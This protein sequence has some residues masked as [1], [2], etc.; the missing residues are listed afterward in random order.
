MGAQK[1]L[2]AGSVT[3][4]QLKDLFRQFEDK[5][6][7]GDHLQALLEHRNPF[8]GEEP[9]EE[10]NYPQTGI[11]WLRIYRKLGME[12]EFRTALPNLNQV[13]ANDNLWWVPVI[14]GLTSNKIVACLR[15]LG[16][17]VD[18]YTNDLDTGVPTN[19]RDPARGSY[20]VCFHRTIEADPEH[21]NKSAQMLTEAGVQG[22]TLLECLLLELAF[23][24]QTGDHLDKENV[25]LC[26]GSRFSDGDVPSVDWD[27]D[28]RQLAVS[29]YDADDQHPSLRTRSVVS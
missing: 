15:R 14:T 28:D 5:S 17:T 16:V 13:V 21:H 25:T 8:E 11:D 3:A 7:N 22:I 2:V 24:L 1:V 4:S 10:V 19:D 12:A 9:P 26:S 6:L 20:T 23:F 18:L 29:W 27:R